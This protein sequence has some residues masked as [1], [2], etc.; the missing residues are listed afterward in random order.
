MFATNLNYQKFNSKIGSRIRY[1]R[2]LKGMSLEDLAV[3]CNN[4]ANQIS[5]I[6]R[7]LQSCT[8]FSLK[9]I[10]EALEVDMCEFFQEDTILNQ[11]I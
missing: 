2:K 6:E 10:A 5:R 9:S 4:H 3:K 7:G 8:M 1:I 11:N